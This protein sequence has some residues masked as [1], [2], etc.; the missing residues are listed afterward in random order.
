MA[1]PVKNLF[2]T[3]KTLTDFIKSGSFND[4]RNIP[5]VKPLANILAEIENGSNV[6]KETDKPEIAKTLYTP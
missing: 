2:K 3:A 5:R 6:L 4:H 1:S